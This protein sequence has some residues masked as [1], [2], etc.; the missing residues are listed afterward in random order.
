MRPDCGG[1]AG[2]ASDGWW[3]HW[4]AGPARRRRARAWSPFGHAVGAI[5]S[6]E[7]PCRRRRAPSPSARHRSAARAR[8]PERLTVLTTP[9]G[10]PGGAASGAEGGAMDGG[11]GA[12]GGGRGGGA[13]GGRG[14]WG[15]AGGRP[16]LGGGLCLL[17]RGERDGHPVIY[18]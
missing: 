15:E 17:V 8:R 6:S 7:P 1:G 4:C 3:C 16:P 5:G 12:G 9:R 11:G 13:G 2:R 10:P 14:G 18:V